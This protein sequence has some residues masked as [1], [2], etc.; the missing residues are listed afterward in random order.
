MPIDTGQRHQ[1]ENIT[2]LRAATA[3]NNI[4]SRKIKKV[5]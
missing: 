4:L 1:G 2:S 5:I 3:R